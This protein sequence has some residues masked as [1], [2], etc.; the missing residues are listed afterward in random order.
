VKRHGAEWKAVVDHPA[1]AEFV[2]LRSKVTD[3]A[4]NSQQQ[5]IVRAYGLV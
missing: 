1:G 5:T 3:T 4:G 2:S